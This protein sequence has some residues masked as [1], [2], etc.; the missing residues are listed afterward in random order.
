MRG[1]FTTFEVATDSDSPS[2]S[3]SFVLQVQCTPNAL[4]R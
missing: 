4:G 3:L 2:G 1:P